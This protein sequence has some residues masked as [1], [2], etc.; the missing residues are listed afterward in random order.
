MLSNHHF[1]NVGPETEK[2][3]PL[4]PISNPTNYL[5]NRN[6]FNFLIVHVSNEEVLE[7]ILK[8]EN[9]A[10]GPQ[11]IPIHLLKLIPDLILVPLCRIISLS[12]STGIF[13]DALKICKTIPIHKGGLTTDIGNYR[14]ISLLSVFD[15]I[16]EKLMHKRLYNFLEEHNILF[17]NQFGC[18]KNNSTSLALIQI[19]EKIKES[20]DNK[21]Y[22]CGIFID[23]RKAFDTVNHSILLTKLEHYG[24]RETAFQWFESYLSNRHQYVFIN[25]E[26]SQ[27]KSVSC[28][29]PQGSVL[30][31]LL[32]LMYINDLPNI[33]N[34]LQ[35]FSLQTIQISIF[36]LVRL[37]N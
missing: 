28:G 21:Q 29:V 26:S 16:I 31:P 35:F 24:I 1:A 14:P 10:T 22:G 36:N 18:R 19:T 12:F 11:S 34:V 37:N 2:S 13:P 32:F 5:A 15:K 9:K 27:L 4:N 6:R 33:S 20:I 17:G 30:G 3:I 8:L 25:G 7:I 23:L